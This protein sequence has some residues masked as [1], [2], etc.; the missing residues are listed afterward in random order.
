M[1]TNKALNDA[2]DN[3]HRELIE[4]DN[5]RALLSAV[6]NEQAVEGSLFNDDT[7]AAMKIR[8]HAKKNG[9]ALVGHEKMAAIRKALKVV[10]RRYGMSR[11]QRR[12]QP[13][14]CEP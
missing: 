7:L 11:K 6:C 5:Y 9:Y 4:D 1:T 3:I 10:I 8:D 12:E 13:I 2:V 14:G